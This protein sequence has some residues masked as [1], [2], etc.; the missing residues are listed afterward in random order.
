MN[1]KNI[2]NILCN[3]NN[4]LLHITTHDGTSLD[5]YLEVITRDMICIKCKVVSVG[6]ENSKIKN[7]QIIES[8]LV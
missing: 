3:S 8:R 5:G 1:Y 2:Q 7:I 6:L 4:Q